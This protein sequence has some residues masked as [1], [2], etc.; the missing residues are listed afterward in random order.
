M[1]KIRAKLTYANVTA[2]IALFVALGGASAFA[3]TELARNSVGTAQVKNGAITPPKL[4]RSAKA[5]A[6][7]PRGLPG[8][9]G[10]QGSPGAT[11][12]TSR[13][14]AEKTTGPGAPLGFTAAFAYCA[15]GEVATGGGFQVL[16]GNEHPEVWLSSPT[17]ANPPQSWEVQLRYVDGLTHTFRAYVI[18]ASP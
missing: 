3:A 11:K 13:F 9:P 15:P 17:E 16:T 1:Q 6:R 14:G 4:S 7:G 18:C 12:V 2:S 8:A 10:P 5:A